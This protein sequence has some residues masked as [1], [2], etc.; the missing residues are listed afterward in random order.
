MRKYHL[1]SSGSSRIFM[2]RNVLATIRDLLLPKLMSGKIRVKE[3]VKKVQAV[4]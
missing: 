3:A 2:S 1:Y 4:A